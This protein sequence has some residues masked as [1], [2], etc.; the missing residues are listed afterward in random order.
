MC[1]ILAIVEVV[2]TSLPSRRS[3]YGDQGQEVS[4]EVRQEHVAQRGQ[5]RIEEQAVEWK[6]KVGIGTRRFVAQRVGSFAQ[7]ILE[8]VHGEP[9]GERCGQR[10]QAESWQHPRSNVAQGH[11]EE[12]SGLSS[13][14]RLAEADA[15]RTGH[16]RRA[17]SRVAGTIGGGRRCRGDQ[18]SRQHGCRS[19]HELTFFEQTGHGGAAP[20]PLSLTRP[21]SY[22][23]R[24]R[25][26][27][28]RC[29]SN[30]LVSSSNV[31]SRP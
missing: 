9:L 25:L 13:G 14:S 12:G 10:H 8:P 3:V 22:A 28:V 4:R 2:F 21:P 17:R 5:E 6:R 24:V 23:R 26:A 31:R 16:P 18:R 11:G 7:R 29:A 27:G 20:A 19:R 1:L 15:N 30:Q